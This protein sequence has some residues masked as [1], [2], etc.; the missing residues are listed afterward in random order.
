MNEKDIYKCL[1]SLTF[2]KI[3]SV[4]KNLSLKKKPKQLIRKR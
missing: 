1:S 4:N 2:V 3:E